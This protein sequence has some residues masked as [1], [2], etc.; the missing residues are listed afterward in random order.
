MI[1]S[2][3]RK[4]ACATAL[5]SAAVLAGAGTAHADFSTVFPA[6]T[7]CRFDLGVVGV[8]GNQQ[9]RTFTDKDGNLVRA[10]SAGTGSALTFT[11]G[12]SKSLSL[13]SNGSVTRTVYNAD[14]SSTVTLTGHNILILF[15]TD[16]PAGPSTTLIVGQA[17]FTVDPFG[18]FT[19]L[20]TTGVSTD[21]CAAL[22]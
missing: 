15:P 7:A 21:I 6:G 20:K 2:I 4:V 16:K 1:S 22:S 19:V 10:L 8:G 9:M 3:A 14:G 5:T 11:N 17:V 18:N 13:R 12:T